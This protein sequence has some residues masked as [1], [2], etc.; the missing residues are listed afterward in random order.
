VALPIST[1]WFRVWSS[2]VDFL[3]RGCVLKSFWE[4]AGA[5]GGPGSGKGTQCGRMVQEFGF[6]HISLG[7][8][9]REEV[10][11]GT[12]VGKECSRIMKEGRLV[13]VNLTLD[14]MRKAMTESKDATGYILDGFPRATSQ[15][16]AFQKEVSDIQA[17][18]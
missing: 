11:Q 3:E 12:S 14:L 15:A 13:P 9:L 2:F 6:K 4:V 1:P 10:K 7:D 18:D 5:A 17:F 16:Q 8:I